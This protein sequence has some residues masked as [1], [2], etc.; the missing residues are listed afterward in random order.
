M[1]KFFNLFALTFIFCLSS[2]FLS[3]E[4]FAGAWTVPRGK[5]YTE[6]YLKYYKHSSEFREKNR[7]YGWGYDGKYREK[8]IELKLEYG[9]NDRLNALLYIPYKEAFWKQSDNKYNASGLTDFVAGFKYKLFDKPVVFSLQTT[10]KIPGDVKKLEAPEISEYG[11]LA[12]EFKMLVGKQLTNFP[13]YVGYEWSFIGPEGRYADAIRNFFEV[14][15]YP[16]RKLMFKGEIE[17]YNSFKMHKKI[18]KDYT[19]WR[20]GIVVNITGGWGQYRKEKQ[21]IL[22]N[23]EFDYENTFAGKN[24]GA[25]EAL[26]TKFICQF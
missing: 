13:A 12:G 9:I 7:R 1:R 16:F 20:A 25:A 8:R 17:S 18:E 10:I 24:T 21:K 26:I 3:S 22:F 2:L 4:L 14:G 6:L 5:L 15:Y 23:W 11:K 19:I